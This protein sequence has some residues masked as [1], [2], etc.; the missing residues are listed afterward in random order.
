MNAQEVEKRLSE[1]HPDY[2]F[3]VGDNSGG[4]FIS[5]VQGDFIWQRNNMTTPESCYRAAKTMIVARG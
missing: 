2:V 3:V 1:E 5:V 4:A